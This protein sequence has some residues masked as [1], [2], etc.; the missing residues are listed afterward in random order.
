MK[1]RGGGDHTRELTLEF[2]HIVHDLYGVK[3]CSLISTPAAGAEF[4]RGGIP[5]RW[6]LFE[7]VDV[8]NGELGSIYIRSSAREGEETEAQ[9]TCMCP[10]MVASLVSQ[11]PRFDSLDVNL[12]DN[13][14]DRRPLT[15]IVVEEGQ[16]RI[17]G[18]SEPEITVIA[19]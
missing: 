2:D 9:L 19:D 18:G 1:R 12:L 6:W 16:R 3:Q 8:N 17:V 7:G 15:G 14:L 11:R 13:V 4:I 5:S 10:I